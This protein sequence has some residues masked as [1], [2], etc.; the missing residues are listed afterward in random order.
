M[1]QNLLQRTADDVSGSIASVHLAV[2]TLEDATKQMR[3]IVTQKFD[4]AI[5]RDDLA[6]V[7]RF[8]KIYPQLNMHKEGIEKFSHYICN[9]LN[10]KHQRD[11]RTCMDVAKAEKRSNVAYAD[12]LTMIFENLAR[13]VEVNQ[14]LLDSYYGNGRLLDLVTVLQRECDQE[15][16]NLLQEFNLN[17]HINR[18]I[19]KIN[20]YIKN[21]GQQARGLGHYRNV[22]GGG[23]IDKLNPKD[24]DMLIGEITIMHS[25]AELYIKFMRR[26]V[27]VYFII[28]F[29]IFD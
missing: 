7:E 16:R 11:L 21:S 6:S 17:R 19:S 5:K 2:N 9:K 29:S 18:R 1:D 24:I 14:P 26:R 12:A 27:K 25:R 13:V 3:D 8:F 23:S 15:M 28:K 10:V 4:D 22:S 20:E